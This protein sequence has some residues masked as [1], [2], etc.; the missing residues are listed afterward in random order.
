M[1][2]R[3][4][5]TAGWWGYFICAA[6]YVVAGIRAGDWLGLAGSFFFLGATVCFMVPHYRNRAERSDD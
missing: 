3:G 6:I 4:F 1:S 2:S 5:I